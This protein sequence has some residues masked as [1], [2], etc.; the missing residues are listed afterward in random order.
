MVHNQRMLVADK[1]LAL[2]AALDTTNQDL[3]VILRGL[4]YNAAT[5]AALIRELERFFGGAET[6]VALA[7]ADLFKGAKAKLGL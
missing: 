2:F 3:A 6:K 5:Y 1:A 7:A 4:N